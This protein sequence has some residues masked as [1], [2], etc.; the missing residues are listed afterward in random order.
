MTSRGETKRKREDDGPRRHAR[1][2]ALHVLYGLDVQGVRESELVERALGAYWAHLEG[3]ID[4]RP[5]GDALVRA[6]TSQLDE[7]DASIQGANSNWRL[8]RMARVDRNILRIAACE[9]AFATD[10]PAEVAIDEAV[11]LAKR[12]GSAESA[13]FVNG[14][15]DKLA[16]MKGRLR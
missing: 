13:A 10:V 6:V 12:F 15:L 2:C 1:E 14:T 16:R 7:I 5:Y 9:I 4:G 8:D 3:P 11:D